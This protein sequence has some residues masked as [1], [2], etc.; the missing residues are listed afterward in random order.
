MGFDSAFKGLIRKLFC[1]PVGRTEIKEDNNIKYDLYVLDENIRSEF[2]W[3][4]IEKSERFYRDDNEH[5]Y[6]I[7][8]IYYLPE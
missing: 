1:E 5:S 4:G 6:S 3:L 2:I 8:V 7:K